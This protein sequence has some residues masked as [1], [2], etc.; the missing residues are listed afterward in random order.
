MKKQIQPMSIGKYVMK[1][2]GGSL[3]LLFPLGMTAQ[4]SSN[5]S[6][7]RTV[8]LDE[9]TIV[10]SNVTRVDNHL[11]IYPNTRQK[12]SSN[13]GYGV[14]K[15]LMI[16]GMIVDMQSNKAEAMG[17]PV[18]FY[19]NGQPADE[20]D[21]QMLR[22]KDIAK[23]EYHDNPTGKYAKDQVVVNFILKEYKAG[24][25][26]QVDGLQ[27]IGYT[28]GDY[29]LATSLNRKH[30]TYS[31]FAG[32]NF[33][34][35]GSNRTGMAE[36]YALPGQ[37]V[38]R[39]SGSDETYSRHSE[40]VQ[41]R[42]QRQKAG[43]Y[44]V[45][46]LSLINNASPRSEVAGTVRTGD[47][48]STFTTSTDQKSLSPKLDLT[49][50]IPL[51]KTQSFTFGLHGTYSRN[52]YNRTYREPDFESGSYE[53][54]NAG[55][56]QLSALYNYS[57]E[58]HSF[59]VE[60]FD[61]HHVWKAQY[62]GSHPLDQSL[63]KNESLAFLSYNYAFTPKLS[64][65][66]R[67]GVDWL[68]YRLHG[69]EKLSKLSPRVVL[70]FQ[71]Q[72]KSGMLLWSSSYN[73]YNY[74]MDLINQA[75]IGLNPYLVQTGNPYLKVGRSFNSYLYYSGKIKKTGLS[76]ILQYK[77]EHN[78]VVHDYYAED[79]YLVKSFTNRG[80]IHYY[81]AILAASHTFNRTFSLSGD[82]RY[83]YTSVHSVCEFGSR[84]LTG[85]LNANV[86]LGDFSF[87]LYINF[88]N[89]IVNTTSLGIEETPVNYGLECT[90]SKGNFFAEVNLVSPF[91]DR[92]FRKTFQ[93][94]LYA[95][96]SD[97]DFKTNS[98]YCHIK[99]AYIL[100]FGRQTKKVRQEVDRTVNSSLLKFF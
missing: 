89:K 50:T 36:H 3:F 68:Q 95:Y 90:Y 44:I 93:H 59:S 16:P 51:S 37:L 28:H 19:I 26:V 85:N 2:I 83:N 100:D 75:R 41:F 58:K 54:E 65:R 98:R 96:D 35:V 42:L 92:K 67:V 71:Y 78:P 91:T 30:T 88:R 38:D 46:K 23:I 86:Y 34:D 76:A 15:R 74:G 49:G 63:W 84:N 82:I 39:T 94:A 11:V 70:N 64:L 6:I 12:K 60:L 5:D 99:L 62:A 55:G 66:S 52:L 45:G 7:S 17:M 69:S 4:T 27:T 47:E 72:L 40:Y 13:S 80:N 53:S 31:V 56:F 18:S 9:V 24:G 14:L 57:K 32:A 81:G 25:Y 29:N 33:F 48:A 20:R 43:R 87:S 61:F 73:N 22:P 77:L 8:A 21:V 10:A 79:T 1:A 97:E